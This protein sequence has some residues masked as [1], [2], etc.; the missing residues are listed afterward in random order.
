MSDTK[1]AKFLRDCWSRDL[2]WE[3]VERYAR[4]PGYPRLSVTREQY[5]RVCSEMDEMLERHFRDH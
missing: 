5:D 4:K 2:P 1:E 3:D